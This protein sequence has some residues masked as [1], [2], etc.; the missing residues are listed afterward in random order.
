MAVSRT[1]AR[2]D[3]ES[4]VH[5]IDRAIMQWP[6]LL[7]RVAINGQASWA[8]VIRHAQCA[9]G[10]LDPDQWF[11]VSEDIGKARREAAAAITVCT[12]CLVRAECLA[13]WLRHWDIGQHGC[14][15]RPGR[16]RT[17]C[18]AAP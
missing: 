13:L 18:I 12:S 16:R 6:F 4:A 2:V 17:R 3:S 14:L 5:T 8:R 10:G 15:G 1:T 9:D 11:P 7:V